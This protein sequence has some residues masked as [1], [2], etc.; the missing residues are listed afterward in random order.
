MGEAYHGLA[1]LKSG[2][3]TDDDVT[4]MRALLA[5]PGL[6]SSERMYMDYALGHALERAGDFTGSFA[7]YQEGARLFHGFFLG[8]GEAYDEE[9][10][11]E[12]VGRLK[13]V[14][15]AQN[16]AGRGAAR[17]P[18]P[19]ATPIF[20]LG[21][22]R[23][24]STL[25][26]QILAS[27][28]QVEGTRELPLIRDIMRDVA[29]SRRMIVENAY[30]QRLLELT[31]RQLAALGERYLEQA[32]VYRKTD[33]HYFID[34]RPWNWLEIGMIHLILPQAR[35]IDIR[36]EPMA[37]CFAMFKQ[38]LLD[39]SDFTYNLRD[40]GHYFT[41]YVS[42]MDHY[43][44]ELPGKIHFLKYE[45]LVEDTETE[46]RRLLDHC[47]LPFEESCLRFWETER[48][49]STPSAEQVR[50][51]IFRGAMDQW[52]N[53]EPWLGPLKAALSEPARS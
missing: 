21:M 32:Q 28:S 18:S 13:H 31:P 25:V 42:L 44:T 5:A 48:A 37:A 30:P 19:A 2:T 11:V 23:A 52:R 38:V 3:L 17:P 7:A 1:D 50:S 15:T 40:L 29:H 12:R 53:Y 39:G 49:I 8:R 6:Q 26:E 16:L 24:G 4:A 20:I 10:F 45:R 47:G 33:C 46:V 36:R 34:K 9:T 35:I 41:E 22:P 43:E 14:F 51:P 27:H